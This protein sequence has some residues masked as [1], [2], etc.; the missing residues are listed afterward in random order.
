LNISTQL[1]DKTAIGKGAAL[2]E[3]SKLV[4]LQRNLENVINDEYTKEQVLENRIRER[5]EI[6]DLFGLDD[7]DTNFEREFKK[8]TQE[9]IEIRELLKNKRAEALAYI[10]KI[11]IEDYLGV[12]GVEDEKYSDK[13]KRTESIAELISNEESSVGLELSGKNSKNLRKLAF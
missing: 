3:A 1:H 6:R 9:E 12:F 10:E 13:I 4:N 11:W 7:L 2:D 5:E 8:L